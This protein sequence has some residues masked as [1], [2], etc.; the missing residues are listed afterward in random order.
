MEVA[1]NFFFR[2]FTYKFGGEIFVQMFGGPIGARITMAVS[3]LVM[4]EWKERYD[5]ILKRSNIHEYLKGLY[6]DDGRSFQRKLMWGERFCKD[7]NKFTFDRDTAEKD[8]N[9]NV[10]RDELTRREILCAMNSVN[11]DLEFTM[12][13]CT[14]FADSKLPT[15]SFSLYMTKTGIEHTYYEK[16]M[17]NQTLIVERSAIGRNQLM[18]IM[19]NEIRRR[20][21]V[22][23]NGV[24]QKDRDEIVNKYTQQLVNSEF[25]WKQCHDIIV[26]GLKGHV[27]KCKRIKKLGKPFY[28][29]GQS[30]LMKR[31][32]E[33]LL[34]K[35]NWFRKNK[36][37]EVSDSDN[38]NEKEE[39]KCEMKKMKKW[40]HYKRKKEKIEG[41]KLEEDEKKENPPKAVLFVPYTANSVLASEIRETVQQLRPWTRLNIK[42]V[43]RAGNK[44]QDILSKSDPWDSI[45]CNREGCFSC[46]SATKYE[47]C[48]F[49][50]CHQ[51]SI[52]YETWCE[53]CRKKNSK[54]NEKSDEKLERGENNMKRKRENKVDDDQKYRYIGESSRS[55]FERGK[56]HKSDLKY[57][58]TRS[59]MLRHCEEIHTNENP[60]EI[61]FGMRLIS[62][63]RTAFERQL[64]EAVYIEMLSGPYLMNSRLE[65]SR[66]NI[67]KMI[68]KLGE[69]EVTDHFKEKEK[70][71]VERLKIKYKGENKRTKKNDGD[72]S[73]KRRKLNDGENDE[74]EEVEVEENAENIDGTEVPKGEINTPEAVTEIVTDSAKIGLKTPSDD[75][76]DQKTYTDR[77]IDP[78]SDLYTDP[79]SDLYCAT[80]FG[81]KSDSNSDKKVEN[82]GISAYFENDLFM[83]KLKLK[84]PKNDSNSNG[85]NLKDSIITP[86]SDSNGVKYTLESDSNGVQKGNNDMKSDARPLVSLI[87]GTP[88]IL[89][90]CAPPMGDATVSI[91]EILN[92]SNGEKV[93]SCHKVNDIKIAL[94]RNV[95]A[96]DDTSVEHDGEANTEVVKRSKSVEITDASN[97]QG[98]LKVL[99]RHLSPKHLPVVSNYTFSGAIQ[100]PSNRRTSPKLVNK[101]PIGVKKK[102]EVFEKEIKSRS[103]VIISPNKIKR[104]EMS[105]RFKMKLNTYEDKNDK[106]KSKLK[107]DKIMSI[108]KIKC[109]KNVIL[110]SIEIENDKTDEEVSNHEAVD[111]KIMKI[112]SKLERKNAFDIMQ[113]SPLGGHT[114]SPK[115]RVRKRKVI[116]LTNRSSGQKSLRDWLKKD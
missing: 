88:E 95:E 89:L 60:D 34:E 67:P 70:N 43:E 80:I 22:I 19:T 4:Q 105:A 65:Y 16:P 23:G 103:Q 56:E 47:N 38:E 111:D 20:L 72:R 104:K 81:Q 33:K 53:T 83:H 69:K 26:S 45:D 36:E 44:I 7:Q 31:A 37:E 85:E 8:E 115:P 52:L 77:N 58:R 92:D 46:D 98:N 99:Q 73:N 14:D 101:I 82:M 30:S 40:Q 100:M 5:Q 6:V 74:S 13:L 75:P 17:K 15:L 93:S 41:L 61:E 3:R 48:K 102:I 29:S 51:R 55:I 1:I 25:S 11:S 42:I 62:S 97:N 39:K 113:N 78:K 96:D 54:K 66:C 57:R 28:R 90:A 27:R 94:N 35:Y 110:E 59:H 76:P 107:D 21:E 79:Q 106:K 91:S 108:E 24:P 86:N 2:N 63:S 71:I 12:E 112:G 114:P 50:N 116:G 9:E 18:S 84:L 87:Q 109:V 49:R 68:M 32:N 10:N 64:K